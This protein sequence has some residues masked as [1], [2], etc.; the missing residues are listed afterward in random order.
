MI[1]LIFA[2]FSHC[3]LRSDG[4]Q[5]NVID[6]VEAF[7]KG[8]LNINSNKKSKR[9]GTCGSGLCINDNIAT[10]KNMQT[11]PQSLPTFAGQN[12]VALY[13]ICPFPVVYLIHV[14]SSAY[15]KYTK[16]FCS[17]SCSYN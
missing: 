7:A 11:M 13:C 2:T 9:F 12:S 8:I 14:L 3:C 1:L 10:S 15:E 5:K 16:P 6:K 17:N 4:V